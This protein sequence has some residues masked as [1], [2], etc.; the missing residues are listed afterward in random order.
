MATIAVGDIHGCILALIDLLGQISRQVT[1]GDRVVF[2]GD[3]IDRGPDTRA[4]IDTILQFREETPADVVRLCGNH[5]DWLL[6]TLRDDHRHS[7]LLGM[8]A[9]ETIRSYSVDA[10]EALHAAALEAGANLVLGDCALPYDLF[11]E[12][13]PANHLE[14]LEG[15]LPCDLGPDCVCAHG[16]LDPGEPSL[17]RQPREAWLWGSDG[18]PEQYAGSETVVYGHR[19][20]AALD[21]SGWPGPRIVGRTIGIDTIAHGVLT[22][23]RM[24]DGA[25]WQSARYAPCQRAR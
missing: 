3:Y 4:C 24:P 9:F 19:N 6:R 22:A 15:L 16:G 18:F 20:N 10:A 23:V 5:E 17:N 12:A 1:P 2:L 25:I 11:F 13:M 14:F 21:A 7:W 8:E